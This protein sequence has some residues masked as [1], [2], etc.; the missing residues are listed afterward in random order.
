MYRNNQRSSNFRRITDLVLLL[1]TRDDVD[2]ELLLLVLISVF[3]TYNNPGDL[4]QPN[5]AQH[6]S[7]RTV[8]TAT[9]TSVGVCFDVGS[10]AGC[11][12][13]P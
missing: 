7:S 1:Y 2:S 12:S 4:A 6:N 13:W 10:P 8:T 9:I 11:S 5:L 3:R